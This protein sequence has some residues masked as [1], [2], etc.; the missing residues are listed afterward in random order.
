MDALKHGLSSI[1]KEDFKVVRRMQDSNKV[2]DTH[3]QQF[4]EG[5]MVGLK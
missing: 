1:S 5:S 2:I 4:V 3:L